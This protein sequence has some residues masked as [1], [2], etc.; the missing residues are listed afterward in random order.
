MKT[1]FTHLFRVFSEPSLLCNRFWR[2]DVIYPITSWF[3]PKQK[4]LTRVIPNTWCD[5]TELVPL[6]NFAIL[7]DFVEKEDGLNQLDMDWDK[8]MK[9]GH[10]SQD[11]VDNV[12]RVYGDLK[13]VYN[14]IKAERPQLEKDL[15]NSYPKPLIHFDEMFTPLPGDCAQMKTTEKI[16]GGSYEEVYAETNRLEKLIDERET[17]ALQKIIEYRRYLWT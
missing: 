12:M 10:V 6:V 13:A 7:I 4:W 1:Y 2:D 3:N 9:D 8:E 17:W 11:Y 5:K 14:Y 15:V 16:Y